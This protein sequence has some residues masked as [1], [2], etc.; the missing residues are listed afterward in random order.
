MSILVRRLVIGA[1]LLAMAPA[2]WA[3]P[4]PPAAPPRAQSGPSPAD[5]SDHFRQ[6]LRLRPDQEG[7][8]Q[9]FVA[10]MRVKPGEAEHFREEAGREATLP[11]PQRLDAMM[12]RMDEMRAVLVTRMLATKVFYGQL[13][14]AQKAI[15]D[16]LPPLAQPTRPPPPPR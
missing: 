16:D 3:Q 7:A 12:A 13:T 6:Q 4:A 8:L 11:T 9:A 5:E 1:A 2:A 14:P 15:F 10:A